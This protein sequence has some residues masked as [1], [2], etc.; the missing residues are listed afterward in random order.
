MGSFENIQTPAEVQTLMKELEERKVELEELA[1]QKQALRLELKE[2]AKKLDEITSLEQ[3]ISKGEEALMELRVQKKQK[4]EYLF[5]TYGERMTL[6]DLKRQTTPVKA[7]GGTGVKSAALDSVRKVL[8]E[9][10]KGLKAVEV[11]EAAGLESATS[12]LNRLR[13]LGEATSDRGIWYK[14][15]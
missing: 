7:K 9:A 2:D 8:A 15:E 6:L 3:K 14:G 4:V 10:S 1:K 13:G 5:E 11:A 12:Q